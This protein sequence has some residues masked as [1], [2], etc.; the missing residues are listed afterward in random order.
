MN[1]GES[2]TRA[3]R[4]NL[5]GLSRTELRSFMEGLGAPAFHGDQ[6]YAWLYGR[7]VL[8]PSAW[9]DLPSAV[10]NRLAVEA[11]V[12]RG[13]IVERTTARD[14]TVKYR[15]ELADGRS[16]ESVYMEQ[17]GRITFCVSSQVGC[18]LACDFCLTGKMGLERHLEPG[19]ILSQ[20]AL[21]R[22]DHDPLPGPRLN[23]VFMGMGEPLHNYA[24]VMGA[25]T[26]LA[27]PVGFGLSRRR[28]TVSTA[29]LAPQIERLAAEPL[30]PKL[31]VSL[32]AATDE[33]RD[34]IMPINR[35]YPLARLL[36]A[37]RE[38]ARASR[39]RITLEYVLLAGVNDGD[40]DLRQLARLVS[41]LPAKLN[42][43]PFNP[44]PGWLD[45][46][47][48][49]RERVTAIRDRLLA[50]G[51]PAS[52]RWSR[53]RDARAACGQLALLAEGRPR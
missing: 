22:R 43:I 42:L 11:R 53:G 20:I 17:S 27:D 1:V 34:R 10:R 38:F 45:Y 30:R 9:T 15:I 37:C 35:R 18:A 36:A 31:A 25:F 3:A 50:A 52:I 29:G 7:D 41:G 19:E 5:W 8:D 48:P 33:L 51:I 21:M 46:R 32:N 26:V 28:V 44:V 14:K 39:E 2:V 47:P 23:I 13:R 16:V 12:E 24:G 4:P 6:I 40:T 49:D